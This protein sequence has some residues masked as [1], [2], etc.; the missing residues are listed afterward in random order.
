MP[1]KAKVFIGSARESMKYVDAI[2]EALSYSAEVT[3]WHTAFTTPNTYNME[4]LERELDNADFAVFVFSPD[5]IVNI[6]DEIL[7]ISRD[8]TLFELGLFWGKLKRKRV[9]FL[10]PDKLPKV[11]GQEVKG[12]RIPTDFTG[13][14]PLQYEV[15]S[16]G[17]HLAAINR[18]CSIIKQEIE[19]LGGFINPHSIIEELHKKDFERSIVIE[20]LFP[21]SK[22][23]LNNPTDKYNALYESLRTAYSTPEGFTVSGGA[24]WKADNNAL[25]HVSGNEG[26]GRSF[27]FDVN[28]GKP[29]EEKIQV[30]DSFLKS[31]DIVILKDDY[32]VKT[33]LLCYPIGNNLVATIHLT[34]SKDELSEESIDLLFMTNYEL[35]RVA[36]HIFGGDAS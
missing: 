15:R 36:N 34:G 29:E 1:N 20:F 4:H 24:I 7:F 23:V 25:S 33:Y 18:P 9:F 32:I 8:N 14:T 22:H 10:M 35:L 6:R 27:A 13:L 11:E 31:E 30:V 28:D 16:D 2:H 3:P 26:K 19:K 12:I 5:D 17:K 21:F